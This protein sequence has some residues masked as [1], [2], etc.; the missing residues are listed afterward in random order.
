M[1]GPEAIPSGMSEEMEEKLLHL[2][3]MHMVKPSPKPC[4][5]NVVTKDLCDLMNDMYEDGIK[6]SK[7]VE[8]MPFS[9]HNTLYYH[10]RE[11]CNH[12]QRRVILYDECGWMRVK[13]KQGAPR[14][15]L[16]VLYDANTRTVTEHVL[17]E[18]EHE[19]GIEPLTKEEFD[20]NT[21]E[22]TYKKRLVC[23]NCNKESRV[24]RHRN[25]RFCSRRC[26]A[27]HAGKV[28]TGAIKSDD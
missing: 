19:D 4:K 9:S 22:Y 21:R 26:A 7:I 8:L 16:A 24:M 10:L 3:E 28:S 27:S 25:R 13:A 20:K 18:C 14:K 15:T 5:P 6:P 17:G 12:K 1:I 2:I 11:D 23:E